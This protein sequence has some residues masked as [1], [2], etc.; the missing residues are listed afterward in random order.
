MLARLD[1]ELAP[2]RASVDREGSILRLTGPGD[3]ARLLPRVANALDAMGYTAVELE[4]AP[5]VPRWFGAHE[6]DEL[7]R[8]EASV[9][10]RRWV[11]D[12]AADAVVA[13]P[14]LL[15]EP[16]QAWLLESFRRA[17]RSGDVSLMPI[18]DS[19]LAAALDREQLETVRRWLE[20]RVPEG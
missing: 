4:T 12:L 8:E 6:V 20:Q 7:S 1:Q 9:L 14:E 15:V 17:A 11:G 3:D 5:E 10:A 18:A 16:L 13:D 2:A 19:P